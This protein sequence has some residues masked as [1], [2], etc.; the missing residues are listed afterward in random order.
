MLDPK[1]IR[2]RTDALRATLAAKRV[3]ADLDRWLQLDE[4]RRELLG[5]VEGLRHQQKAAS[6]GIAAAK[7]SGGDASAVLAQMKDIATRLK[8]LEREL[9][10]VEPAQ[11]EIA[12]WFPNI[13][14]E[15]VPHGGPE[16]NQVLRHWG[17]IPRKDFEVRAHYDIAEA[18]GLLDLGRATKISGSGFVLWKGTGA[19]LRRALIRFML[20][21]HVHEH[22]YTEVS[23][24][25]LISRESLFGTGQL[26]KL[27]DDM[28]HV[29]KDDLFLNPTAEVPLTNMFRD[30]TFDEDE[31]PLK[32][33][34]YCPSFR[35]EAGSAGRDTRGIVRV[36]QFDKV[37]IV[38]ITTA[39][40]G[41]AEHEALLQDAEDILQ[42][43][44]VPYRVVFIAD[45]D[46][47]FSGAKQWDLELYAAG[48]GGRWL[49]VSSCST[50]EEFQARRIGIRYR[51]GGAAGKAR[52][53]H[54]MNASGVALP[55]LMVALLENGQNADGTITLPP[56]LAPYM[57]GLTEIA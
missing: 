38:K 45:G 6:D 50:F 1:T 22:G 52:L 29:S 20:D 30:E 3:D 12:R 10:E 47:G 14:H 41:Y 21:L 40:S 33:T 55:R 34:G 2:S 17:E 26:P 39:E 19:K 5:E 53:A 44:G 56:A 42:R 48:E 16:A 13:V 49:E 4:R 36:H 31:L 51:P 57:D 27:E 35:R 18:L 9:A 54:T 37:E 15:S 7:K 24:P 8:G 32:V 46:M 23:P 11:E 28:Y 43:L 25:Y